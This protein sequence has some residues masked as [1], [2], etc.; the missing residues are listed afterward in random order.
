MAGPSS[1]LILASS[2]EHDL[3]YVPIY[4]HQSDFVYICYSSKIKPCNTYRHLKDGSIREE[5]ISLVTSLELV[6]F[7]NSFFISG[8]LLLFHSTWASQFAIIERRLDA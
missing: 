2:G 7:P 6:L 8:V 5:I 4:S 3:L 1:Q